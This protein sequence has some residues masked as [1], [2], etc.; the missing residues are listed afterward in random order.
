MESTGLGV[1][2]N[3]EESVKILDADEITIKKRERHSW[4]GA[5]S[6]VFFG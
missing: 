2:I 4:S 6:L 3:N 5:I 1:E